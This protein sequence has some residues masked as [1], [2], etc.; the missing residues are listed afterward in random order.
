V[1]EIIVLICRIQIVAMAKFWVKTV[2]AGA[3]VAMLK[4]DTIIAIVVEPS[5]TL[6]Q[7][8]RRV[9]ISRANLAYQRPNLEV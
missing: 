6:H 1:R 9:Q 7:R 3:K 8:R 4:S 5:P 2:E